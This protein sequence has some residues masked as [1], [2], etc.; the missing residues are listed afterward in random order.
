MIERKLSLQVKLGR[1][2][3]YVLLMGLRKEER[4]GGP[5][6]GLWEEHVFILQANPETSPCDACSVNVSSVFPIVT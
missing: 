2:R 5:L 6:T 3:F 4:P 1:V